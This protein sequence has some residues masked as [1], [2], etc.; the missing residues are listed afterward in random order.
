M[1]YNSILLD[2]FERV[3]WRSLV[4]LAF[5]KCVWGMVFDELSCPY[6]QEKWVKKVSRA[7][8]W[9]EGRD[10]AFQG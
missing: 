9:S 1:T 3:T 7:F 10:G 8:P 4:I 5:R 2:A 6:S